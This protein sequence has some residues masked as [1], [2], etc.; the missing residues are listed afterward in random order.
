MVLLR[1]DQASERT[2]AAPEGV[3]SAP[4]APVERLVERARGGDR[5]AFTELYRGHGAMVHAVLLARVARADAEDLTQ[6][7]FL[8]AWRKLGALRDGE[9][10]GAWLVSIARSRAADWARAHGRRR[11]HEGRAARG[12]ASGEAVE[13]S[14]ETRADAVLEAIRSLPDAYREPLTMRLVAGMTG[15]Q[16]AERL[17]MTHGSVRVNL[18]RGMAKL[19][20]TLAEDRR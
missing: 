3:A 4:C 16:I 14:G 5:A 10:F 15:V 19:R 8:A 7:V 12:E 11:R 13:A 2:G 20:E 9:S 6:E 17:G 18:H 1:I